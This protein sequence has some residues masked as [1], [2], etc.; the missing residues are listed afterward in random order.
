MITIQILIS[1]TILHLNRCVGLRLQ[2]LEKKSV[3]G[4]SLSLFGIVVVVAVQS[5]F[6]LEMHQN[7]VFLFFLKSFLTSAHLKT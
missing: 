7:N 2:L 3:A 5:V 6:R 4:V 1:Q